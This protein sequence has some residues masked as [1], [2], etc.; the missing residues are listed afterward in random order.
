VSQIGSMRPWS[1][2]T[3]R[4]SQPFLNVVVCAATRFRPIRDDVARQITE[5]ESADKRRGRCSYT[6]RS[7]GRC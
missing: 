5:Q 3:N 1:H 7:A 4:M 6:R 2:G